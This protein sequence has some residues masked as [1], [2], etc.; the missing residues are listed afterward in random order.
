VTVLTGNVV[1]EARRLKQQLDGDIVIYA[2]YQLAQTLL[3]HDL[4]DEPR[5]FI[6]PV[7][8]GDGER[9]FGE[10]SGTRLFRLTDSRNRRKRP[11]IPHLRD[12]PAVPRRRTRTK[13]QLR[14]LSRSGPA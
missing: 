4:V 6:Y 13:S 3:E 1:D 11:H 2:S 8:V 10:T 14:L 7:I 12:R 5:L 9:L